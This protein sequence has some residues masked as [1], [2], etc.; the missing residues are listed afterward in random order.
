MIWI[1]DL[2][3]TL[4]DASHAVFPAMTANMNTFI[5]RHIGKNGEPLSLESANAI[6]LLYWK[7]YGATIL[8]MIR[9]HGVK[10]EEFL[11]ASHDL[12]DLALLIKAERGL[13]RILRRLPGRKI[14]LT[15]AD[16]GYSRRV[17][18]YLG[19]HRH[20][21]RH[22]SIQSMWVHGQLLPKPSKRLLRKLLASERICPSQCVLVEDSEA[23]L[24]AGKAIGMRTALITRYTGRDRLSGH[25]SPLKKRREQKNRPAFVDVKAQ[26]IRQL[27]GHLAKFR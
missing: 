25:A 22:V 5:A 9:H 16:H 4:H 1:F 19:L 13:E 12:G 26:S 8:G 24:K 14:L 21:D 23:T 6:R 18:R 10:P 17:L 11:K 15:N 7:R 27:P 20:F 3:N 2:D